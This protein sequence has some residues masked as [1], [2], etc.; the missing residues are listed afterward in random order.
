MPEMREYTFKI[1]RF[2]PEKDKASRWESFTIMMDP[3]ERV[4]DGLNRIKDTLDGTLTFRKSCAH[5]VCG[6]C[7]MKINGKNMLACSVLV[8][9]LPQHIEVE[10]LAAL[11]VIKDL[12]VQMEVFFA[13]NDKV[14]PYLINNDPAPERERLQSPEDQHK[15]V[16]AITCIMCGSC[17][18]SCPSF[19]TD[20]EYLGP[21]ALLKAARFILDTRDQATDERL[22][23]VAQMDGLWRCHSIYNCV[24]ACPKEIDVTGHISRLKR[25]AVKKRFTGKTR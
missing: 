4:L 21:S 13:K 18:T 8:Q 1:K 25:L 24:E 22:E 17:S 2:D 19:W 14:M 23:K 5:G 6:S 9:D 12:A 3:T 20:K 15:I 10:P 11:P 7:A 16:Q